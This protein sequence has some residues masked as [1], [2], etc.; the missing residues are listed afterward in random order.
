MQVNDPVTQSNDSR[1]GVAYRA[2][3]VPE[4]LQ[5]VNFDFFI[6]QAAENILKHLFLWRFN[7][8]FIAK[9]AEDLAFF[10][11]MFPLS[12]GKLWF[13]PGFPQANL[14]ALHFPCVSSNES[15][16]AKRRPQVVVILHQGA[17]DAM[18]NGAGLAKTA[19]A[20]H[21]DF[22]IKALCHF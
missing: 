16:L 1:G 22:D 6:K 3:W 17:C 13:L 2:L 19:A 15:R 14:L 12:F 5:I 18:A 8:S 20:A 10:D 7:F 9:S 21:C 11:S 4:I